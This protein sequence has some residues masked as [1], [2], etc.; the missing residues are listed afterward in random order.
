MKTPPFTR[1][2]FTSLWLS[3]FLLLPA[4]V[5]GAPPDLTAAGV[6]A[7]INRSATYNLGATGLRGWIYLSG[8]AGNTHGA[9]GTMTGESRQILVT[10]AS[11][12]GN[13][14]LAVDDVILGAMAAN[15]GTV[16]LFTSDARKAFG[17]AIGEAEKTGAGT[18]RVKRWR[19]GTVTDENIPMAIMG[20]YTATAPY[21]CDK[22]QL[23][24]ANARNKLVSQLLANSNFLTNDWSGAIS[25]LALLAGV[26][27]GDPDYATVQTRLQTYAR[28]RA[29]AGPQPVGL[30]IW[31]WAYSG[32]FLAEYYLATGDANVLPGINSYTLK[33]AQSQSINGTFGHG[34][35]T[36]RPDGSGRRMGIGYGPVNAVGI[37]ANIAIVLGKKALLA[38]GQ[39]ID[40]EIDGAIQRG[41]DFFAFYVNK[42]PIPYGEHE[43]F[44]SGHSSNG[45]D[46]M[47]AV[48]FG[49]Q[50]GRAAETEYYSRMTTASY[51]GRE[52]GH[53]GQGFSYL[54]S[55][56]GAN[57][58]GAL[59]V[60]EHLK[61]VRWHLDLSRR[62]DGSFAY[63]GA[64][65]F[66]GGSTSDGTYLGASGYYGMNATASYILTYS[67]PL[68]R[69]Y[70]TGKRDTPA[71]PPPLTLD[72]PTGAH[73]VA[74]ANFKVDCP[75][76]TIAQL[77]TSLSDYDPVVRHYAV[78]EVGK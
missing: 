6:I 68:Q 76:F 31:D 2:L 75:G 5:H 53:T 20:D 54:W 35:S 70:I 30:P 7:T 22:S 72:A 77:I 18:L 45:K 64:E 65:Q 28:A 36:L 73:A 19:A 66:G 23:I 63:D 3:L 39:T 43:P 4:W 37:V 24:L 52:Y 60:A 51:K 12:P 48:L 42:G 78:I 44:I 25:A 34:P 27:P 38:G 46:P 49:L 62:T 32:L 74:A 21:N 9:D 71:D 50:A 10:V 57:M 69:L 33:L 67:L 13:A 17:A 14:V 47:C 8:G 58:G 55:A 61:P 11:A 41:S 40:P 29:T 1:P 26:Q 59:A 15:S 56:M 16:P